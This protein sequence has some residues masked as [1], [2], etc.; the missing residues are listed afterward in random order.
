MS[1]TV[2]VGA[3][4]GIGRAIAEELAGADPARALL[5]ADVDAEHAQDAAQALAARG[6]DASAVK[7][8]VRDPDSVADLVAQSSAADRVAIA[9]GIFRTSPALTTPVSEFEEVLRVNAIGCFHVAQQYAAAMARSG[10]GAIVG[11]ASIAARMPRMRQAAYSASKAAL[12]QALRVL[13][14][15][16]LSDGVRINTVSPGAT[17][18]EMMRQLAGDHSSVADLADGSLEALRPRIP[19]GRVGT[20]RDIAS[21]VSFLLSPASDHVAMQDIVVDGG[22]LLGM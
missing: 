10:G 17:D 5:I 4:R 8:D 18:T 20:A 3:A 13:A 22:E 6:V 15:E 12:R 1:L 19:A 2:I 7:V 21:V 16:V 14:M 9:A 11:V